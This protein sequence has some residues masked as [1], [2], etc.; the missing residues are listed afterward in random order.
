MNQELLK[1]VERVAREKNIDP[2]SV[3]MDLESAIYMAI[4][5]SNPDEEISVEISRESG[6]I[7]A[8]LDGEEMAMEDLGRIAAQTAKQVI[9]QKIRESE[10][11]SIYEEYLDRRGEIIT[12]RVMRWEGGALVVSLGRVE[13]Y[14][15]KSEQIPGDSHQVDSR[16]RAMILDVRRQPGSVKVI[17]S[18]T[19]PDFIKTLFEIEVPEVHEGVVEIDPIAREAGYRTKIAVRSNDP[20]VDAVGSCV[21]V[22]GSRIKNIVDELGGEKIDI[23]RWNESSKVLIANALK[24]AEISEIALCFELGRA[25]VVVAESQL[26]LAI[27][28]RGQNVRLAARLTNWDIDIFVASEYNAGLDILEN[29]L[30]QV[31]GVDSTILDQISAL[32][33]VSVMDVEE[34]GTSPLVN[35]LQMEPEL[36]GKIVI[37]CAEEAKR[38]AEAKEKALEEKKKAKAAPK[39]A[40]AQKPEEVENTDVPQTEA[41]TE[42]ETEKEDASGVD[43]ES[44]IEVEDVEQVEDVAAGESDDVSVDSEANNGGEESA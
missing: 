4:R 20:K 18:R 22:R 26:S 1:T 5:K 9:I 14:L 13:A 38:V 23:V 19:H 36:A 34:V 33:M 21:G 11:G 35:E 25:T 28:K 3:F 29:T 41:E 44:K 24:P 16:I 15:P 31:E 8:T 37:R 12:G 39:A 30:R 43:V 27:G 40:P 42:A 10:R 17:L 6:Q 32:G 7:R 2:E